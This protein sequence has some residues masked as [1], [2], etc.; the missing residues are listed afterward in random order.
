MELFANGA[1]H[2]NVLLVLV[3]LCIRLEVKL[4]VVGVGHDH[5]SLLHVHTY[6]Q[7]SLQREVRVLNVLP[8]HLLVLVEKVRIFELLNGLLGDL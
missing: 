2:D 1:L 4:I 3:V 6:R 8:V 7:N 5:F